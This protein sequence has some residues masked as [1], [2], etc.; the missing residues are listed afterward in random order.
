MARPLRVCIINNMPPIDRAEKMTIRLTDGELK[1]RDE[2]SRRLGI[3]ASGTMRQALL[4]LGES[5]GIVLP[6][7]K[8]PDPKG[9]GRRKKV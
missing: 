6:E 8:E 4:K 9:P 2:I 3:S 1:V 5:M 7:T